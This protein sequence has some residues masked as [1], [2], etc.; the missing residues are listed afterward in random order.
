MESCPLLLTVRASQHSGGTDC[1]VMSYK[2]V[3]E[4]RR[5]TSSEFPSPPWRSNAI[6][7]VPISLCEA[8]GPPSSAGSP[9]PGAGAKSGVKARLGALTDGPETHRAI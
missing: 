4:K 9:L 5:N 1:L 2:R 8:G 7:F 3:K 6:G